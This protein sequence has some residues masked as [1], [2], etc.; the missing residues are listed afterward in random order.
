MV[1][2]KLGGSVSASARQKHLA[3]A[4]P[5]DVHLPLPAP[6]GVVAS[7]VVAAAN[8]GTVYSLVLGFEWDHPGF[9]PWH[10]H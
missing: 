6:L 8:A 3:L 1:P 4:L 7:P 10:G 9:E 2:I 5:R